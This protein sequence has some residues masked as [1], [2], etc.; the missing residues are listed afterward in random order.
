M[1]V[2]KDSQ[3]DI[4]SSALDNLVRVFRLDPERWIIS[5]ISV[6]MGDIGLF[7]DSDPDAPLFETTTDV[8]RGMDPGSVT[9]DISMRYGLRHLCPLCG[10]VAAI[11][12]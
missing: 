4:A 7:S 2:C 1:T 11:H 8:I 3:K 10:R 12:Q 6:D 5:G 9:V